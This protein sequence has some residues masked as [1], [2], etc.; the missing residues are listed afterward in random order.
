MG[1]PYIKHKIRSLGPAEFAADFTFCHRS[2]DQD[3]LEIAPND[4]DGLVTS[5]RYLVYNSW[6]RKLGAFRDLAPVSAS[7]RY[8]PYF[9]YYCTQTDIRDTPQLLPKYL[10]LINLLNAD[11]LVDNNGVL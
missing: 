5:R 9:G 3:C 1:N 2:S 4:A 10:Y 11:N 6:Y 8:N 7:Y